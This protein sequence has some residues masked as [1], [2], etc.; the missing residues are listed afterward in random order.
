MNNTDYRLYSFVNMYLT[1][2]HAGI[3][4]AHL[5]GNLACRMS[6]APA[7]SD[8]MKTYQTWLG[9][10]KTIIVLNGGST[11]NM[12]NIVDDVAQAGKEFVVPWASF[13]ESHDALG[14]IM[15]AVGIILPP[16]VYNDTSPYAPR[17]ARLV[18]SSKLAN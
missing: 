1:G 5:V 18:N 10:D 8:E 12:Q 7:D 13:S 15:T 16:V 9:I 2:I 6:V 11:G 3:Q 17:I 14:G 4:T